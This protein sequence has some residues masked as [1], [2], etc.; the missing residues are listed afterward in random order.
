MKEANLIKLPPGIG[1]IVVKE[2]RK[3][4]HVPRLRPGGCLSLEFTQEE[5]N[6]IEELE[7]VN[8]IEADF[9]GI[10]NLKGLKSLS[11]NTYG[12]PC[13][14]SLKDTCS[15]SDRQTIEICKLTSLE[16]LK[17]NNQTNLSHIDLGDLVNL[18]SFTINNNINL[19]EIAGL[20]NLK[21]LESITC[22]GNT[23]LLK[24]DNLNE[25]IMKNELD[26]LNLDV[27]L[28][29][30]VIKYDPMSR[31]HSEEV[32]E[33]LS[34]IPHESKWHESLPGENK[35]S[36]YLN[37]MRMMHDQSIKII[38]KYIYPSGQD[39]DFIIGVEL[40]LSKNVKYDDNGVKDA[41][42][43]HRI[44]DGVVAQGPQRGINGAFNAIMLNTC[45]CEGYTRA[46]Q[47]LL[48]L[49]G[50][51]SRNAHCIAG[52]DKLGFADGKNET[53]YTI[54]S[55]PRG[56][57]HSIICIEDMDCLYS[58]PCW[59][60][61]LYQQSQ[62]KSKLEYTLLTK[63]QISKTHTLS[64][65]ERNISNNRRPLDRQKIRHSAMKYED[66]EMTVPG[67]LGK[68]R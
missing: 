32:L 46:M 26:A 56:G 61:G 19:R 35:I 63:E 57:Y 34:N 39:I 30:E 41:S 25:C 52:E 4:G 24:I 10:S 5:L 8:R 20:E 9:I 58:D 12:R 16:N 31:T 54:Y 15:I 48:K 14:K 3:K 1:L 28:Y 45:V 42:R 36:I 44:D 38:D 59:N 22:Y 43:T 51:R 55:L 13:Y 64:F 7:V 23:S 47:Y 53:E 6:S 33:K 66:I 68:S 11:I 27:L 18:R 49:G 65:A 50:I 29:P 60:A 37:Q 17:I 62:G 67:H 40:Y 21:K 2:L